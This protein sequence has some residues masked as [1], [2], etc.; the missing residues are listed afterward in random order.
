MRRIG[1]ALLAAAALA[2][3]P[4]PHRGN[5]GHFNRLSV[6]T[7]LVNTNDAFTGLD[8]LRLGGHGDTLRTRACETGSEANNEDADFIP[9]PAATTR[10]SATLRARWSACTLELPAWRPEPGR[11]RLDRPRRVNRDRARLT[12]TTRRRAPAPASA[13]FSLS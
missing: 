13:D 12:P 10:L 9:G 2:V 8:S 4:W 5:A 7:M 1:L 6:L 11:L 3:P